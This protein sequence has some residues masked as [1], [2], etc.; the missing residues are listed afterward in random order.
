MRSAVET[1]ARF[2]KQVIDFSAIHI[3]RKSVDTGILGPEGLDYRTCGG[4]AAEGGQIAG[5][6]D[7]GRLLQFGYLGDTAD[8]AVYVSCDDP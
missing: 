6:Y 1:D 5:K 4:F 8:A 3:A 7:A 2:L